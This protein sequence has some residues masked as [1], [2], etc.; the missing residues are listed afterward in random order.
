M[1]KYKAIQGDSLD[2]TCFKYY[3][4]LDK[5]IYS[6][7]LRA[8]EHLLQKRFLDSD[9]IVNLPNIKIEEKKVKQLWE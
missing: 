9:D 7:F 4:T 5:K 6:T 1:M 3:K 2:M 8:N